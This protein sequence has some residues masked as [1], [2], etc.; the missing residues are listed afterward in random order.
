M[1]NKTLTKAEKIHRLKSCGKP[2]SMCAVK[3]I[4]HNGLEKPVKKGKLL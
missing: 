4:D 2:V 1:V 3:V